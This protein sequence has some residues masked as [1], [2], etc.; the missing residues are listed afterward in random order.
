MRSF[1]A[2]LL[3][4]SVLA[5]DHRPPTGE[6]VREAAKPAVLSKDDAGFL[7][8]LIR[9]FLF[10]PRG[11]VRVRVP[12]VGPHVRSDATREGWLV[13]EAGGTGRVY[14]ADGASVPAP[15]RD[16]IQPFSFLIACR[17]RY[18]GGWRPWQTDSLM[19]ST[20]WD[21]HA[22]PDLA[23]AAWLRRLG[24]D[25]LAAKALA[26]ARSQENENPRERMR[27]DLAESAA[28]TLQDAFTVRADGDAIAHGEQLLCTFADIAD[29]RHPRAAAMFADLMRRRAA[30]T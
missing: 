5:A 10:D 2:L 28:E 12:A 23:L 22:E 16:K 8:G 14:F 21:R 29:A 13:E 17:Q 26:A 25:D 18:Q 24:H 3:A 7:D 27:R 11:A 4:C 19:V 9:D 15:P 1:V 20:L 30:G 6:A